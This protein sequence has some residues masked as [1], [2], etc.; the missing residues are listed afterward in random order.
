MIILA[1]D[2][3]TEID[4]ELVRNYFRS[5][6]NCILK[7]LPMKESREDSLVVYMRSLQSEL[8]GCN[9]LINAMNNDAGFLSLLS[10]LQYQID[11]PDCPVNDTR[12]EV[13]RAIAICNKLKSR[14]LEEVL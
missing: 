3:G 5:L 14:Y 8:A 12:R 10:I 4:T 7:I 6:V 11:N 9:R 1:I 2:D 13:F